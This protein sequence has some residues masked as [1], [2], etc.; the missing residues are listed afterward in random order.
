MNNGPDTNIR[1]LQR[2]GPKI[3]EKLAKLE[4]HTVYD[5]LMHAPFRYNDFSQIVP[6]SNTKAGQTFTIKAQVKSIANVISKNGKKMQIANLS[7]STGN[8]ECIWFHQPYL[9]SIIKKGSF[10]RISG[11]VQWFGRKKAVI[12]PD[13][14]IVPEKENGSESLHT[15]RLVPIYHE[16]EGISSKWLRGRIADILGHD[17]LIPRDILPLDI[18][19]KNHLPDLKTALKSIHFPDTLTSAEKAR[20][21]MAF[22]EMFLIKLRSVREK[23]IWQSSQKSYRINV[24]RISLSEFISKLPFILTYD[25]KKALNDIVLDLEKSF[26]MNRL[27]VG[28]VG[29]GKTVVAAG[30]M[31]LMHLTGLKSV[32]MA[33]TQILANQHF[34]SLQNLLDKFGMDINL[35]TSS[36]KNIN[37]NNNQAAVTVGT[38]ALLGQKEIF[39]QVGLVVIDEEQRFGVGQRELLREKT[40]T[41]STPHLLTMT[42]TPIPRTVAMSLYGNLDF[43][44]I[45]S[46]PTGRIPVKTWVIP[47]NKRA[48]AYEWMKTQ[49]RSENTQAFV[50]CPFINDSD[51][52]DDVKSVISEYKKLTENI[53]PDFRIKMLHGRL[54]PKEKEEILNQFRDHEFDVLVSTPVVE[55]G[56]D[57]P[58]AAVILIE[59]ADRFGLAQLHQLRGRVGRR[60]IKSYCLLFTESDDEKVIIRL[61]HLE[62]ISN[63]PK[64]SEIDLKL[65]GAGELFG[66]RQHGIPNLKFASYFDNDLIL[67]TQNAAIAIDDADPDLKSNSLLRD[68]FEKSIIP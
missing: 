20:T 56:I 51:N 48:K 22:E 59:G 35:I 8:I 67:K 58:D 26:P 9:L 27:L 15:G 29:S 17:D 64:L 2:V 4:I 21:R 42:A 32:L 50:V 36:H 24:N 46:M 54:K 31:Y 66:T 10:I 63:G 45:E 68:Y 3:A 23:R 37:S 55:V 60:L 47:K 14:E 30:V 11:E 62:T 28:D 34:L 43:S 18:K 13:F 65:R 41:G 16:T 6:I 25:Q 12:S 57:I 53:F 33:P 40:K 44:L 49:I 1:Y 38:H 5:L 61:K 39:E 7:D 19:V 52:L